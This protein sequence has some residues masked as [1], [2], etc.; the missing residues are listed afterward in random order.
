M[1]DR[2]IQLVKI[3]LQTGRC[4]I[5]GFSL[6]I[7]IF[8]WDAFCKIVRYLMMVWTWRLLE[9]IK[10]SQA[11]PHMFM[12]LWQRKNKFYHHKDFFGKKYILPFHL[13][14]FWLILPCLFLLIRFFSPNRVWH[15][16]LW[17]SYKTYVICTFIVGFKNLEQDREHCVNRS[18]KPPS[19]ETV[20]QDS[21]KRESFTSQ[22][23]LIDPLW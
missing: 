16:L 4:G 6:T 21:P 2:T 20:N 11:M 15:E 14:V 1:V 18:I 22:N 8:A 17:S 3:S 12:L 5:V 9:W 7:K 10:L 19:S 23:Y 13:I